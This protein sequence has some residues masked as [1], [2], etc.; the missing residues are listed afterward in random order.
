MIKLK[1]K[2]KIHNIRENNNNGDFIQELIDS[3]RYYFWIK[4]TVKYN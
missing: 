3:H 1:L 2:Y 4:A